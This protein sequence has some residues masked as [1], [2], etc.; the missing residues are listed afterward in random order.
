MH[1]RTAGRLRPR[2]LVTLACATLGLAV[3]PMARADAQ[4]QYAGASASSREGSGPLAAA[5]AREAERL[6]RENGSLGPADASSSPSIHRGWAPRHPIAA[7][8]VGM[9][10]CPTADPFTGRCGCETPDCRPLGGRGRAESATGTLAGALA[11][12]LLVAATR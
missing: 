12:L 6:A 2:A 5:V 7:A 8:L 1:I 11:R 10:G 9:G 3:L 4:S